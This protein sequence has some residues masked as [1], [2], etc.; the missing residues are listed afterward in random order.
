MSAPGDDDDADRTIFSPGK[1][2]DG[3]PG[4]VAPPP[5]YSPI[6]VTPG[7]PAPAFGQAP[8]GFG[9]AA[10]PAFGVPVSAPPGFGTPAAADPHAA[11][12]RFDFAGVEPILYGPEPL[13]AAAGRLIHLASHI[14]TLAI[15]P[16]MDSL[17]RLIVQELEAFTRRARALGLEQKSIQLAHYILCAF[18]D[19]AVMSTPWGASSPWSRQS[20][21][22]AYHN[23]TQGGDRMFHFAEQME[24]DPNREPRLVELLYLCLSL[25]FEGRAALVPQ[26]QSLLHARRAGLAALIAHQRGAQPADISPQWRGKTIASGPFAPRI[27]L[28]A[29]LAGIALLALLVFALLLFRL[30]SKADVA[31]A[32]LDHAVGNQVTT[33][34]APAPQS[35]TPTYGKINEILAPDIQSGRLELLREGNEIVIRLHNQG[36]FA[37]AQADASS[38]WSDTFGRIAQAANL[39]KGPIRCEGHTDDQA[40]RSLQFPS[41]QELSEARAKSVAEAIGSAGLADKSRLSTAG[42]G[43]TRPIGDNKTDDGRRE[44]RRV[45]LRVANDINWR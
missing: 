7:Q 28:W 25:G 32:S 34:P 24:R 37:S 13:V 30:S 33:P 6:P 2:P 5:A 23:D 26:G 20:L 14:K 12:G 10:P 16:D 11:P 31:I 29:V 21:L 42:L 1:L 19:D 8:Q 36:L 4:P 43:A 27:P 15:G 38:S 39:T 35:A 41:N 45:E 22:A 9:Q 3:Q 40:I 44:N 18:V 17:R